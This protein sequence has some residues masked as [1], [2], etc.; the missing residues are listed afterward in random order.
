MT[1]PTMPVV[2]QRYRLRVRPVEGMECPEC[3]TLPG[4]FMLRQGMNN[5]VVT[6]LNEASGKTWI[7]SICD[8]QREGTLPTGWFGINLWNPKW[9]LAVPYTWLE[10]IEEEVPDA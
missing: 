5:R 4:E 2:G 6:V 3:K 9:W 7:C 10:P 8:T 1:L